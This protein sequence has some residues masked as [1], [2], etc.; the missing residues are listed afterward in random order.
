MDAS[1]S[2]K[3]SQKNLGVSQVLDIIGVRAITQY[4]RDCYRLVHR[5][6][7][8]FETLENEYN[9]YIATPKPNGYRSI[10]LTVI[11]TSGF[12]VEIQLHTQWMHRI[13]EAGPASHQ[14]YKMNRVHWMHFPEAPKHSHDTLTSEVRTA[15]INS[16]ISPAGRKERKN[17]HGKE[18]CPTSPTR[19]RAERPSLTLSS[20]QTVVFRHRHRHRST[21]V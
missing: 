1:I 21:T 20:H 2:K 13:S 11:G 16:Q 15:A 6:R 3:M 14:Q 18:V 19:W 7:D 8:N 17:T 9:D 5:I 10:H 4:T 12:P